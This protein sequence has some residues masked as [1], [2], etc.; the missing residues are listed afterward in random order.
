L[1]RKSKEQLAAERREASIRRD[2]ALAWLKHVRGLG[3]RVKS[4]QREIDFQREVMDGVKSV[5]M[6]D[7]VSKG[8]V[9][10]D[11]I[12]DSIARLEDLIKDYCKELVV[13]VD[14]QKEAHDA[15]R[16][17]PQKDQASVVTKRFLIGE[18]NREIAFS[19]GYTMGEV[20]ALERAGLESVYDFMPQYWRDKEP[21]RERDF[22]EMFRAYIMESM[23]YR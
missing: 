22:N 13:Y 6:G 5:G 20:V 19:L 7:N 15:I 1:A 12:P 3:A 23:D 21:E 11:A 10:S 17:L 8:S 4:L 9:Y 14:A 2:K 18:E 16:R